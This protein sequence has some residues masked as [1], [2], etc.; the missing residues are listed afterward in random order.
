MVGGAQMAFAYI[1]PGARHNVSNI[2]TK[3]FEHVYAA[4]RAELRSE[5][6]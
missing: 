1:P 6:K 2:V 3:P 4:A 5:G